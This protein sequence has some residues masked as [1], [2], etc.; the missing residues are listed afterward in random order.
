MLINDRSPAAKSKSGPAKSAVNHRAS[1]NGMAGPV[2]EGNPNTI[3]SRQIATPVAIVISIR[4][5]F[6]DPY[7]LI[8]RSLRYRT[9]LAM[10]ATGIGVK[11]ALSYK[12]DSFV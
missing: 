2:I 3:G 4:E 12:F 9:K 8:N 7:L 1:A 11:G 6:I 10:V 5:D